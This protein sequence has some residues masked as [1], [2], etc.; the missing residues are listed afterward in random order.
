MGV[1]DE[2]ELP[3]PEMLEAGT[4][5]IAWLDFLDD[6]ETVVTSVFLAMWSKLPPEV[7]QSG[8]MAW[9]ARPRDTSSPVAANTAHPQGVRLNE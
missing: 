2:I 3:T 8:Y 5:A 1:D 6:P 4:D 9:L 7:V